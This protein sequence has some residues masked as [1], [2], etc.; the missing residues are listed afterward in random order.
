MSGEEQQVSAD[1]IP[2]GFEASH[3]E[4]TQDNNIQVRNCRTKKFNI[5]LLN[6]NMLDHCSRLACYNYL[7]IISKKQHMVVI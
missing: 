1:S 5:H 4:T 7:M 6:W 3:L 2:V